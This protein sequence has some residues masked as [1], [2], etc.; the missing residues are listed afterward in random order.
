ML[1]HFWPGSDRD[2]SREQAEE[3]YPGE[4]VL[5]TEGLAVELR[6]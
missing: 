1:S 4:I 5:A 6:P 2:V 3:V